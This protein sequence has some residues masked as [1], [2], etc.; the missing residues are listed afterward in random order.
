MINL[1]V[2]VAAIAISLATT[3][4]ALAQTTTIYQPPLTVIEELDRALTYYGSGDKIHLIP[5]DG[6]YDTEIMIEQIGKG[7]VLATNNLTK[8]EPN[9]TGTVINYYWN[10]DEYGSIQV[11]FTTHNG[12]SQVGIIS[13]FDGETTLMHTKLKSL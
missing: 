7:I 10:L 2:T 9:E 1:K 12:F 5:G 4:P 13:V 3:F 6:L 11:V 8:I